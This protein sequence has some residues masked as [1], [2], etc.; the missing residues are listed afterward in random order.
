M[1]PA[2]AFESPKTDSNKKRK[3][4]TE[5]SIDGRSKIKQSGTSVINLSD[6]KNVMKI[7]EKYNMNTEDVDP[8]FNSEIHSQAKVDF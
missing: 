1:F 7:F 6:Q 4:S 5:N 8:K 2:K 3:N